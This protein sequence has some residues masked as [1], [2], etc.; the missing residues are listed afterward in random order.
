MFEGLWFVFLISTCVFC[1]CCWFWRAFSEQKSLVFNVVECLD[2]CWWFWFFGSGLRKLSQ[3]QV[4]NISTYIIFPETLEFRIYFCPQLEEE[5]ILKIPCVWT[6]APVQ[7]LRN[8]SLLP[9]SLVSPSAHFRLLC[10]FIFL[11][12]CSS[13]CFFAVPF[14]K[15]CGLPF[16]T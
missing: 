6:I 5:S 11:G 15:P 13:C 16:R 8:A 3:T 14:P 12:V 10:A 4:G 7:L 1:C 9:W 2:H